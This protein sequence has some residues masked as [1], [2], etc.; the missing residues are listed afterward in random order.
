MFW[1]QNNL[2]KFSFSQENSEKWIN[3]TLHL[4]SLILFHLI[5]WQSPFY[6]SDYISLQ[7]PITSLSK[8]NCVDAFSLYPER[9]FLT[10]DCK[11]ILFRREDSFYMTFSYHLHEY[12]SPLSGVFLLR[13]KINQGT[14]WRLVCVLDRIRLH[15]N[16][17]FQETLGK[18]NLGF[19]S[20]SLWGPWSWV[21]P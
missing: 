18:C 13:L 11:K 9:C 12:F 4:S 10:W 14:R 17:F 8:N 7:V 20:F 2:L 15:S 19:H 21:N 5:S 1:K 6:Q 16:P 3:L